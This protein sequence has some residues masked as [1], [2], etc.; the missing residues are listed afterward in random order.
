MCPAWGVV[1]KIKKATHKHVVPKDIA[2]KALKAAKELE[3]I[4]M[5]SREDVVKVYKEALEESKR[6]Q[7]LLKAEWFVKDVDRPGRK[8]KRR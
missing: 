5:P 6:L 2:K 1:T 4:P 8:L 7:K 3:Q